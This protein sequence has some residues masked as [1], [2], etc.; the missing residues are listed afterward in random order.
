M[1]S[2]DPQSHLATIP[3][4][5]C[6]NNQKVWRRPFHTFKTTR[7]L[8]E[9]FYFLF[10]S[11]N[12]RA[13]KNSSILAFFQQ[14]TLQLTVEKPQ[15]YQVGQTGLLFIFTEQWWSCWPLFRSPETF[16]KICVPKRAWALNKR[17]QLDCPLLFIQKLGLKWSQN[18]ILGA[19]TWHLLGQTAP[20]SVRPM[21]ESDQSENTF[22]FVWEK[23]VVIKPK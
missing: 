13:S 10:T 18:G 15:V 1:L 14:G 8:V 7:F 23:L 9:A 20:S 5:T 6:C 19:E 11:W 4:K 21:L 3:I 22:F 12:E 2:S 16:P 17:I